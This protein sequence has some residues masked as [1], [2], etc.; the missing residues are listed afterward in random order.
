M[1]LSQ[2]SDQTDRELVRKLSTTFARKRSSSSTMATPNTSLYVC[3]LEI[4]IKK[5]GALLFSLCSLDD[6]RLT[7]KIHRRN[8]SSSL[9]SLFNLRQGNRYSRYSYKRCDAKYCIRRLQGSTREYCSFE[10]ARWRR[11]LWSSTGKPSSSPP[12]SFTTP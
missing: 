6:G 4:S 8:T 9:L 2:S 10:S 11:V 7:K 1:N 12:S 3:N 5:D